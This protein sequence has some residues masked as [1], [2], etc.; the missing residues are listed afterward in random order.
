MPSL[1]WIITLDIS[2]KQAVLVRKGKVTQYLGCPFKIAK[3]ISTLGVIQV[4]DIDRACNTGSN[5]QIIKDLARK[6]H[7]YNGGGIR[8]Y[9]DAVEMLNAGCKRVILG[10]AA[11]TLQH[12]IASNRIII[13]LDINDE[14]YIM[15]HGRHK[16]STKHIKDITMKDEMMYSITLHNNEGSSNGLTDNQ[17][18]LIPSG[19][20][21]SIAIAGGINT[22]EDVKLLWKHNFI[23][24]LG[25]AIH[26]NQ[27]TM[28]DLFV[29]SLSNKASLMTDCSS[30]NNNCNSLSNDSS[31]YNPVSNNNIGLSVNNNISSSDNV[32]SSNSSNNTK[33]H[34]THNKTPLYPI[35][36]CDQ[37]K[38]LLGLVY[39]NKDTIKKSIDQKR[40]IFW[41]RSRQQEWYK[42]ETSGNVFNVISVS[43]DCD[44]D[45]IHYVCNSVNDNGV[46]ISKNKNDSNDNLTKFDS[47]NINGNDNTK[48]SNNGSNNKNFNSNTNT[49]SNIK[50][51]PFCHTGQYSCFPTRNQ[52]TLDAIYKHII[53]S[54]ASKSSYSKKLIQ[55]EN[56][57]FCKLQEE[58]YELSSAPTYNN[59]VHE[60]ADIFYF[61]VLLMISK[62]I[63]PNELQDELLTRK[64]AIKSPK[65][66]IS[67]ENEIQNVRIAISV[68]KFFGSIPEFL[69]TIGITCKHVGSNRSLK[70]VS[71]F[72]NKEHK[73]VKC[74]T[75]KTKPKDIA[76]LASNNKIDV[77]IAFDDI[78]IN[79]HVPS[80]NWYKPLK[81]D[82]IVPK[83]AVIGRE[84]HTIEELQNSDTKLFI[85]SEYVKQTE[86]WCYDNNINAKVEFSY[87]SCEGY[88]ISG[89]CDL[90][91]CVVSTGKTLKDNGLEIV[92]IV[93]NTKLG[94]YGFDESTKK[95]FE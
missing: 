58:L 40:A 11:D 80:Y 57:I 32:S 69:S 85:I 35:V 44:R 30:C 1:P 84:K 59:L 4:I 17:L 91:V 60:L 63:T 21:N 71:E 36:V 62:N 83:I 39:G 24:Q 38:N 94:I 2:N 86:K 31:N 67:K 26:T 14:G 79:K 61:L 78:V 29:M 87:G 48:N 51:V 88:L 64:Y 47:H 37:Y 27:F 68:D 74:T 75:I 66:K 76:M 9:D 95:Y 41:S 34:V 33:D 42:G 3:K 50:E 10:T 28:G 73:N 43:A 12:Q 56:L 45:A 54:C 8:T 22:L 46:N 20:S 23:A 65:K 15:T 25:N 19:K 16:T 5:K 52:Y 92:D 6:Y 7:I 93:H 77:F 53:R 89:I 70:Y 82:N 55:D 81:L 18:N 13:A 90:V 72:D 49:T